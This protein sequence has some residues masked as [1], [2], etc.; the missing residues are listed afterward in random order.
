MIGGWLGSWFGGWSGGG[1]TTSAE[2]TIGNIRDRMIELVADH[3]PASLA[4]DRFTPW[5]S[6]AEIASAL[7]HAP[8]SAFRRF[9]IRCDYVEDMPAVTNAD[10]ARLAARMVLAVG[11]PAT[12][13]AADGRSRDQVISADSRAIEFLIGATGRANFSG[14]HSCTPRGVSFDVDRASDAIHFLL[15]IVDLSYVATLT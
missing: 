1:S 15:G 12:H 11:Y 7:E 2:V 9:A 5:R 3:V 8:V 10:T 13:R 14:N 4:A 6:D